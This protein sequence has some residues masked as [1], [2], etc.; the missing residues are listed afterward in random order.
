MEKLEDASAELSLNSS[1][2][3][4]VMANVLFANDT[5]WLTQ[6]VMSELFGGKTPA[7]SKHLKNI[8][9]SKELIP[10]ATVSKMEI[11]QIEGERQVIL[12]PQAC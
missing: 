7:V 3:G 2:D 11:V 5:F 9:E 10:E 8:Y 4:K 1:A 6:S 12:S